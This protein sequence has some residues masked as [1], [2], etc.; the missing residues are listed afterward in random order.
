MEEA[1]GH[2][3]NITRDR[4][5]CLDFQHRIGYS[6]DFLMCEGYRYVS[7]CYLPA[8]PPPLPRFF[9]SSETRGWPATHSISSFLVMLFTG[10]FWL[11]W[12]LTVINE[13][14]EALV[15]ST[16]G[17]RA[18]HG[19]PTLGETVAGAVLGD[20]LLDN[21][22]GIFSAFML[23]YF[24]GLPGLLD[25]WYKRSWK[26]EHRPAFCGRYWWKIHLTFLVL[27]VCNVGPLWVTPEGCDFKQPYTCTNIGFILG[28][29]LQMALI[30]FSAVWWLR[31]P[32][33]YKYIWNPAGVSTR[34]LVILFFFWFLFD[35]LVAPQNY[36]GVVPVWF[37]PIIG[38]WAQVWLAVF[39]WFVIMV[40]T[41]VL[42]NKGCRSRWHKIYFSNA[43][44][45]S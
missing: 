31:K 23:M 29:L 14:W 26:A 17:L 7:A 8:A 32:D 43:D 36:A 45:E 2:F 13:I 16:Y 28:T 42:M 22:M 18:L 3:F 4:R 1:L 5:H 11:A 38:E 39:V 12:G 44:R 19:N 21:L 27:L 6:L 30:L 40:S 37:V 15:P 35:W 10:Q 25:P 34:R 20:L 24:F 41:F 9:S 33:D